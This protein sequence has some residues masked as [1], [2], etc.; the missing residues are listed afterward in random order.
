MSRQVKGVLFADYVRMIRAAKHV[1]WEN[2]LSP[3]DLQ[4]LAQRIDGNAWYPMEAYE[5]LGLAILDGIAQGKFELARAWGRQTIDE[6]QSSLPELFA[7][8]PRE[9]FMRFQVVRQALFNFPA[10]EVIAIRDGKATIA[11]R[12]GMSARAEEAAAWQSVGFLERLM[13][14]SGGKNVAAKIDSRAWDG[15]P[16]T[17]ISVTWA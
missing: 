13:E 1:A 10:A 14:I 16:S 9:T 2:H 11:V 4:Y 7:G 5:H 8:D 15:A 17:R 6:L 3:Q 12:Y